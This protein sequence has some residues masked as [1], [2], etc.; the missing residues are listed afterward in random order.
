MLR[1]H[2]L[3]TLRRL[4]RHKGV[5]S[6]NG[7]GLA[8]ALA[9]TF[10]LGLFVEYERGYDEFHDRADDI[11]LLMEE[12]TGPSG[13][14]AS[15]LTRMPV[16]PTLVREM[17]EVATGTR[18]RRYNTPWLGGPNSRQEVIPT[19]VDSTFFDVF[20]FEV[21]RG[22]AHAAVTMPNTVALTASVARALFGDANPVGQ[23]LDVDFGRDT[24]RVAAVVADPPGNS[25]IQFEALMAR[26]TVSEALAQIGG[27]Y[28]TNTTAYVRLT[29]SASREALSDKLPAF[30]ERH[31]EQH[32][33]G[34]SVLALQP[35]VEEHARFTNSAT[36]IQ[37]LGGLALALL[38]IA[39][40]N[41]TNLMAAY[42]LDRVGAMGMRRALGARRNTL[43]AQFLTESVV[44]AGIALAGAVGLVTA[45]LPRFNQL[46]DLSLTIDWLYHGPIMLGVALGAGLLVG[47]YPALHLTR[48][49]PSEA[50]RGRLA[51]SAAGQRVRTGLVVLQFAVSAAL[52]IGAV[53]VWQQIDHMK[54]QDPGVQHENVVVMEVRT[55][56]FDSLTTVDMRLRALRDRLLR[57]PGVEGVSFSDVV[58]TNYKG[59][60]N[61]YVPS[62]SGGEGIRFRQV[63]VD[64]AYFET[65]G[66]GLTDGNP[67]RTKA[68]QKRW[69]T[70]EGAI[71][72][73]VAAER[74]RAATGD[75]TA[76]GTTLLAGGSSFQVEVRDV[77]TPFRFQSATHASTPV[78]HYYSGDH[79]SHYQYMSVRMAPGPVQDVM[80][81]LRAE[82]TRLYADLPFDFF[83]IDDAFDRLYRTQER[84][85]TLA[86]LT[87]GLAILLACLGLLSLSAF[88]I[89][90]RLK[91]IS[92]RKVLGASVASIVALLS[93][94]FLV[95]VGGA[96][97]L[98]APGAYLLLDWWL[99][100]F[101]TRI[102]LGPGLFLVTGLGIALLAVLT[103]GSQ[104]ARAACVDPAQTLRSE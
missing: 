79:P 81:T 91:E 16:L 83:F 14:S 101:A 60:F 45:A 73:P 61:T 92:V 7:A 50:L 12:E 26:Q 56:P 13:T 9:A 77:T 95:L 20:D 100:D 59:N 17:P 6:I 75:S 2:L 104:A 51:H 57:D 27:W 63:Q 40:I 90:Q 62:G 34:T 99:S 53:G 11:Y 76:K 87:A 10:L 103:V 52:I 42:G 93:K 55:E 70:G 25:S 31:F 46:L 80:D 69:L 44:I 43:A 24:Y 35:L 71:V 1:N 72:N 84:I 82:W 98:A 36:L 67:F 30:S 78:L 86:G 85:G 21:L 41:S 58:P 33:G 66:I 3:V 15:E 4:R 89:H 96:F 48:V 32:E 64:Q 88:S 18:I 54:S 39:A 65:Y 19:Y 28:N 8:L 23:T 74:I 5:V 102:T 47:A 94:H 49:R 29:P 97:A 68:T 22:D 37:L 38:L